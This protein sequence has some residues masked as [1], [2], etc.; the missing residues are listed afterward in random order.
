M[1]NGQAE[2]EELVYTA[3]DIETF[4]SHLAHWYEEERIS[5]KDVLRDP[6]RM[7]ISLYELS[8]A[9]KSRRLDPQNRPEFSCQDAYAMIR[10]LHR[11]YLRVGRQ[12]TVIRPERLIAAMRAVRSRRKRQTEN[13]AT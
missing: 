12:K 3:K 10:R 7:Y 2:A 13:P 4:L 1:G 8:A 5:D 9:R 11:R 6:I